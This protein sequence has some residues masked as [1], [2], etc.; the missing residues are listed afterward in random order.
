MTQSTTAFT[1][2]RSAVCYQLKLHLLGM[3]PQISRRVLVRAD[4]TLAELHHIFQVVMGW[5]NWHLHSFKLW[6]KEYGIPYGVLLSDRFTRQACNY[7]IYKIQLVMVIYPVRKAII[8]DK[9]DTP[10]I[11]LGIALFSLFLGC[12]FR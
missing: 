1:P 5:E 12:P 10:S 8:F 11:V 4:T 3:S 9:P 6:G 7:L 2:D